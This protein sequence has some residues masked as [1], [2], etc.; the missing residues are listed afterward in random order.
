MLRRELHLGCGGD[1]AEDCRRTCTRGTRD[2]LFI[3]KRE[4]AV[5]PPNDRQ[6]R[7]INIKI[8]NN[9]YNGL[10]LTCGRKAGANELAILHTRLRLRPDRPTA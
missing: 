8:A 7:E 5:Q 9:L 3:P 4:P 10:H 6:D 2:S 1:Y